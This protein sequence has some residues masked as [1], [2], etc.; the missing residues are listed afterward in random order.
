[1]DANNETTQ[2][3]KKSKKWL[4]PVIVAAVMISVAVIAVAVFIY[5]ATS[6]TRKYKKQLSIGEKYYTNLDFESA[7]LAYEE[8]IQI[9]PKDDTAYLAVGRCYSALANEYEDKGDLDKVIASLQS[10]LDILAEGYA[11]T[12]SSRIMDYSS[13]QQMKLDSIKKDNGLLIEEIEPTTDVGEVYKAYILAIESN[14]PV[15]SPYNTEFDSGKIFFSI[16]YVDDD[17]LP[18]LIID[19]SGGW[20]VCA[21]TYR[22]GTIEQITAGMKDSTMKTSYFE[23]LGVLKITWL[24]EMGVEED[25]TYTRT[26]SIK[27][28]KMDAFP[29]YEMDRTYFVDINENETG[30]KER[31][32]FRYDN[33]SEGTDITEDEFNKALHD[34]GV[35]TAAEKSFS[36]DYS[37]KDILDQ[38]YALIQ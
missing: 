27:Y 12:G 28:Y 21:Y 38:L 9:N 6:T 3:V 24:K 32:Y 15:F 19:E 14:D 20:N 30:E 29:F 13:V 35:D 17:D 8:A 23:K 4:I 26:D 11:Q 10:A 25:G 18:D 33:A 16:G 1:M 34:F 22:N 5:A 36:G 37:K 31:R 2:V 7:I